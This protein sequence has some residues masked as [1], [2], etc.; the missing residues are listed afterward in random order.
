MTRQELSS[1]ILYWAQVQRALDR[2]SGDMT[3][4]DDDMMTVG[5][6]Y[7]HGVSADDCACQIIADRADRAETTN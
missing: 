4:H 3:L 2:R 7:R 1:R 5:M 6:G